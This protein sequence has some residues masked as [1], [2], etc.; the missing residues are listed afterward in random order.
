[1]YLYYFGSLLNFWMFFVNEAP[2]KIAVPTV[3]TRGKVSTWVNDITT[4]VEAS[5]IL[6]QWTLLTWR[7]Q[8]RVI[9]SQYQGWEFRKS[10]T[11]TIAINHSPTRFAYYRIWQSNLLPQLFSCQFG[12][13]QCSWSVTGWIK[14]ACGLVVVYYYLWIYIIVYSHYSEP[15]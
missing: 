8:T 7:Q 15:C 1:M 13:V 6:S 3:K 4:V 12:L 10:I 2:I 14:L 11:I 9:V 5:E